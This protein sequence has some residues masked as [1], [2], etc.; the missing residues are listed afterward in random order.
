M[1]SSQGVRSESAA[2]TT[3]RK[4]IMIYFIEATQKLIQSEGID[5]LSIRKIATEA[6]YNSAT[7]YNY[8]QDLEHLT[9]FASVCYLRDYV[10]ALANSLK[11]DMNSLDRFRTIYHCFNEF[12]FHYPDIFH[13]MFF[14][15]HSGMLGEVLHTYYYEL[16]PEELA[17][18]S[19]PLRQMMVSGSMMER[20]G[21]TVRAM[22]EDGFIAPEKAEIT[23][24]LII[25]AHQNVIYEACL[26]GEGQDTQALKDKFDHMFDYL[27]AAAA[28]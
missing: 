19:E 20:D 16:F 15:R 4:R 27:L 23:Q 1:A 12:A 18:I 26:R 14:G 3:K 5:G 13:N 24:Q 7:I 11:P 9:L 28:R 2:L 21:I 17:G 22:V 25:A 8:F 6:G 10:I